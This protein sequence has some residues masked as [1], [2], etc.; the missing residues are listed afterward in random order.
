MGVQRVDRAGIG[1]RVA[2]SVVGDGQRR[3]G[4]N[5]QRM[6]S[7]SRKPPSC[8]T[9]SNPGRLLTTSPESVKKILGTTT[10]PWRRTAIRWP[11]RSCW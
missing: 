4:V 8:N 6:I 5:S 2:R 9:I 10:S 11:S 7:V 1:H 3:V